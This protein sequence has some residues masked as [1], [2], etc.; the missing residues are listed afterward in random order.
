[1]KNSTSFLVNVVCPTKYIS[2]T[3]CNKKLTKRNVK[4]AHKNSIPKKE[5]YVHIYL[6]LK[7]STWL[8]DKLPNSSA[9]EIDAADCKTFRPAMT[10][11]LI[12]ENSTYRKKKKISLK[13]G[14]QIGFFLNLAKT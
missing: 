12:V 5:K 13:Q 3:V 4:I 9:I 7:K 8:S 1:M 11:P 10:P 2:S 14:F 6:F